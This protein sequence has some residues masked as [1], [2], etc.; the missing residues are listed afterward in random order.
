MKPIRIAK[1]TRGRA[2][3]RRPSAEHRRNGSVWSEQDDLEQTLRAEPFD[4]T[5]VYV[6]GIGNKPPPSVLKCQWDQALFGTG[7]GQRTRMV[8]WVNRDRYPEPLHATCE[9]ADHSEGLDPAGLSESFRLRSVTMDEGSADAE[10]KAVIQRCL[11]SHSAGTKQKLAATLEQLADRLIAA[12]ASVAGAR[13]A[14]AGPQP[15]VL[16]LPRWARDRLTRRFTRLLLEDV[17][18]YFFTSQLSESIDRKFVERLSSG[19]PFVVIGHSLGSVIAYRNLCRS[20]FRRGSVAL[21]LT[22][23][24]P[25]GLQEV[26]DQLKASMGVDRLSKPDCVRNWVNLADR[27]D[28]VAADLRLANDIDRSIMD[29]RVANLGRPWHPHS[30]TGYLGLPACRTAVRRIVGPAFSQPVFSFSVAKDLTDK[31]EDSIRIEEPSSSEPAETHPVLIELGRAGGDDL[32]EARKVLLER[33]RQTL[34]E[35]SFGRIKFTQ[36]RRYLAAELT[37]LQIES[38]GPVLKRYRVGRIWNDSEK[39]ALASARVMHRQD[40]VH[41]VAAERVY[42]A[43]GSGIR[44]AVL[45]TG[46]EPRHPH[47]RSH[48]N[49]EAMWDC[50]HGEPELDDEL[51]D[52]IDRHGHGTH[53]AAIIAGEVDQR[54]AS[55]KAVNGIAPKTKLHIYKVLDRAGRGRDSYIIRAIDHIAAINDAAA[56]NVIHGV[57]LSLGGPFDPETYGCGHSP[58]CRELRRLWRQ[59]VLVVVSAGNS[60]FVELQSS[61]GVVRANLDLSIGDPANLEDSI[62]VGSVHRDNPLSYGTSFFSSRGPTADGRQKPDLVAPGERVPSANFAFEFSDPYIEMSGTSMAAPHVSGLLAA[63]LSQRRELIGEPDQV[64]SLLLN[65]CTSLSRDR[66]VQGAGIPNLVRMLMAT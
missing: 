33:I 41:A 28:P 65:N 58:I 12:S 56:A 10:I 4:G 18:D 55:E 49:I 34:G 39:M 8:H 50:T 27:F 64:K 40:P 51:A 17:H 21:F 22:L 20:D 24:S 47:F 66:Y 57:N 53:V 52:P 44:W 62:A 14:V 31:V 1:G 32:E 11:E 43:D 36:L 23:G 63:F 5:V 38:L 46:V 45:D 61:G 13:A 35:R 37:G 15:E 25:L 2:E 30:A 7:M 48:T 42:R 26:Q 29:R 60:G 54:T 6:H 59:G 9:D 19:G 3:V 16:P